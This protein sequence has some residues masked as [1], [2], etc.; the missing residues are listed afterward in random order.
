MILQA[1]YYLFCLFDCVHVSFIPVN[2]PELTAYIDTI[3][4]LLQGVAKKK[5]APHQKWFTWIIMATNNKN[6]NKSYVVVFT[7]ELYVSLSSICN[8]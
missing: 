7:C 3:L 6:V 2:T 4:L 1:S 8:S 5:G